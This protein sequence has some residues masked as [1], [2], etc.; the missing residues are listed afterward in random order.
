MCLERESAHKGFH[1]WDEQLL[2]K[3]GRYHAVQAV[4]ASPSEPTGWERGLSGWDRGYTPID[5]KIDGPLLASTSEM[6]IKL[7]PLFD[8]AAPV[9]LRERLLRALE[10]IG[11]SV[12]REHY[13]D[14]VVDLCT[15]LECLL[16]GKDDPKKGEAISLRMMLLARELELGFVHPGIPY[17]LYGLRP[18]VVHGSAIGACGRSD[19]A[20]LRHV[21]LDVLLRLLELSQSKSSMTRISQV[22]K[23]IENEPNLVWTINW[24]KKQGDPISKTPATYAPERLNQV[25]I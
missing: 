6:A 13:D 2:Q 9:R 11:T 14:K 16:T 25:A 8:K 1:V 3:R 19:Y 24:L 21:A 15:A 5:L 7:Q 17:G 22:I 18:E 4:D 20:T 10:W 12:T 23:V